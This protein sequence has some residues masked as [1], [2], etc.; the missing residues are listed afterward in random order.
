MPGKT[1]GQRSLVGY[2][3]WGHKRVRH[4]LVAKQQWPKYS[5][6]TLAF[7][8]MWLDLLQLLL[9][10]R[11]KLDMDSYVVLRGRRNY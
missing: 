11:E 6:K 10:E 8:I 5:L 9:P 1:R 3:L 4:D 2:S 7:R